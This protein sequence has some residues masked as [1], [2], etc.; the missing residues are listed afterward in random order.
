MNCWGFDWNSFHVFHHSF[1]K[2]WVVSQQW[3]RHACR[4]FLPASKIRPATQPMKRHN[5]SLTGI[6]LFRHSIVF[7]TIQGTK[8]DKR[9]LHDGLPLTRQLSQRFACEVGRFISFIRVLGPLDTWLL[10]LKAG[11]WTELL[12]TLKTVYEPESKPR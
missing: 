7:V 12:L 9:Q 4:V 3:E 8:A 5:S 10:F 2:T 6:D 1:G 11:I